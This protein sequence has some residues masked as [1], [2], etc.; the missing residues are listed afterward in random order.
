MNRN[1]ACF[2]ALISFSV[3][4]LN[5]ARA[6]LK[7]DQTTVELHP[8]FGDKEA[9]G[10][11]KYENIGKTPVR[12][13]SVHPSCGCTTAQSQLESVAPGEKG[14]ITATFKIGD[15]T[16]L[17]IKTVTVEMEDPAHTVTVL[18]LK[19]VLPEGLSVVPAFVYWMGG[20]EPKPKTIYVKAG[21][22]FP[23]RN[24]TVT[25]ANAEFLTKVEPTG[26][27]EWKIN[28]QPKGTA[29]PVSTR[30]TIQPDFPKESP[31]LYYA[32]ASVTAMATP[33]RAEQ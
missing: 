3:L 18:T 5:S 21:K 28:I 2:F 19:T 16:G 29:R 9:V 20:E 6:E 31:R 27:G 23:A 25:S 15:R 17:Q 8:S 11:F 14:E 24:L 26:P 12:F 33:P 32:N 7:W 1:S 4:A 10:H 30:L 22:D 13:K